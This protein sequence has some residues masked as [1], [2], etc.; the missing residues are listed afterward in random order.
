MKTLAYLVSLILV[1]MVHCTT[2]D[3]RK[4]PS[5]AQVKPVVDEYFGIK[6]SD[7]Y[8]Y[9]ENLKDSAVLGWFKEQ[10]V[11]SRSIL[12]NIPGRQNLINKMLE[13]NGRKSSQFNRLNITDNDRYF[14]LKT[15]PANETGKLYYRDGFDGKETLLYDPEKHSADTTQTFAISSISPSHDGS[16]I[17]FSIAPNGSESGEILIINVE[18]LQIY[19]E[20]I[21]R[22]WWG[23]PSWLPEGDGFFYNRLQSGD[24]H[25][26]NRVLD[27]KTYL[28]R[29]GT[30]P[31]IDM[32]IFSRIKNPELDIH[33]EDISWVVYNEDC[34]Y[35]FAYVYK[36]EGLSVYYATYSELPSK[37][38]PWKKL[39]EPEDE[40]INFFTTDKEIY[41]YTP[42]DAPNFKILK[43]SLLNPDLGTAETVVPEDPHRLLCPFSIFRISSE[44]LFYDL[45]E[46]GVKTTLFFLPKGEKTSKEIELPFAAGTLI[47]DTKGY[48]F[49]DVWIKIRGWTSD[50]QRYRYST[51]TNEFT[52]ENLSSKP[53][54]PEYADL[55]VEELMIPSHD[56]EEVPLSLIYKKNIK[57]DKKNPVYF[58]GYGAYGTSINPFYDPNLL[59]WTNDGGILAIPHVRG[60]GELG[61]QWYKG[62]LKVNKP[63]TW[64]DLIA[65]AEYLVSENYTSPKKIA[66]YSLSAGGILV[67]RA[68]TDRPDLF[69]A[70]IIDVGVMNPL[71]YEETPTGPFNVSEFGTVQDSIECM[72]LIEMDSYLNIKDGV[73]YPATLITAGINDPRVIAWQPAKYA[74]RLQAASASGKPILFRTDFE[75]GHGSSTKTTEYESL[76]DILS[77]AFWQTGH[78]DYQIE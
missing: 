34:Q 60:G 70:A 21:D 22:H 8:R 28:H 68:M 59:L 13:F 44:G 72:A 63:N 67:G 50:I 69:A 19:P 32:E 31:T 77:F 66:I 78:L 35:L 27:S 73:K 23:V 12:N 56:G 10:S 48:R 5:L 45:G 74:A 17:A 51:E 26:K 47:I 42:K 4:Q 33:P 37:K 76:A 58:Y 36:V 53:E 52:I 29:L 30:D 18:T 2:N 9:M 39:F 62:G 16:K 15:T 65:C 61:N 57:K 25:Q 46:N 40:V 1:I 41:V 43:M 75:S 7:P 14:Y 49:K 20:R 55:K 6:I 24:V 3:T 54:Y 38:I 11:Y 64:K 71:R